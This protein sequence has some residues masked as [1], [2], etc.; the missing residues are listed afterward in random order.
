MVP[1]PPLNIGTTVCAGSVYYFPENA[2]SSP[3]PHYFVV[4]NKNPLTDAVLL[5]LCATSRLDGA[6]A[7]RHL[8]PNTLVQV[9][10]AEYPDF[11]TDS[12]FDCNNVFEISTR[13]LQ[14]IYDSGRL[15]VKGVMP[16]ATLER[17]RDAVIES[18]LVDGETKD[19]LI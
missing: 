19:M 5:L 17:L 10:P 12:I 13:E 11:R 4:L 6:R 1:P 14:Q 2:L 15:Q 18:D 3:E 8:R 7:R 9:S 16:P